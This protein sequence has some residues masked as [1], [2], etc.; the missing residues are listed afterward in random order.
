M[1]Y[2]ISKPVNEKTDN[3]CELPVLTYGTRF[4][5]PLPKKDKD[6]IISFNEQR[7][8][9]YDDI[10]NNYDS[11]RHIKVEVTVNKDSTVFLFTGTATQGGETIKYNSGFTIDKKIKAK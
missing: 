1:Y 6:I 11:P 3:F 4:N 2:T 8:E 5:M 9:I 10:I 7:Q